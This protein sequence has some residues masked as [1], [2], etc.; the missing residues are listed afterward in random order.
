LYLRAFHSTGEGQMR[1][2]IDHDLRA[3]YEYLK[4]IPCIASPGHT[5]N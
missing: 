5:C 1:F 4:A 2:G 3:I